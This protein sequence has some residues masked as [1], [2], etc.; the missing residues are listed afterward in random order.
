MDNKHLYAPPWTSEQGFDE[1]G[2]PNLTLLQRID[3]LADC[4]QR[5]L[6]E[7]AFG[8]VNALSMQMWG[9]TL[10]ALIKKT[11]GEI[12]VGSTWG[13]SPLVPLLKEAYHKQRKDE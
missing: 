10:T 1:T 11:S 3:A 6:W 5:E 13:P 4:I 2:N 12:R 8:H 7:D 9:E